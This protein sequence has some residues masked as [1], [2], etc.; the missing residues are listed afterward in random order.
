MKNDMKN[1]LYNIKKKLHTK[2]VILCVSF[3][4]LCI[5]LKRGRRAI[6]G[7]YVHSFNRYSLCLAVF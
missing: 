4:Y 1:K 5:F 6:L 2:A 7:N 3:P